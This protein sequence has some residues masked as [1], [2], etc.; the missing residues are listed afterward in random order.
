MFEV[1]ID[2]INEKP[3]A[4]N[5]VGLT[6]LFFVDLMIKFYPKDAQ[7]QYQTLIEK[8]DPFRK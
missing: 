1:V 3:K 2:Y 6:F 7:T 8:L 4:M 5:D